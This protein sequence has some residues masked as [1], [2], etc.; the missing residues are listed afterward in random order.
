MSK[1]Q[2]VE[3]RYKEDLR[4]LGRAIDSAINPNGKKIN[5][6]VLLM[7][8]LGDLKTRMNYLSNGEREDVI[9]ALK[10][11]IAQAEG[12]VNKPSDVQ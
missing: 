12:R 4:K 9:V 10:E 11:F 1:E 8:G 2:P 5:G 3:E 6:F 7:F